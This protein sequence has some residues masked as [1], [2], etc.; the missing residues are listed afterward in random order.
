MAFGKG[1]VTIADS[2][3]KDSSVLKH[4]ALIAK[5]KYGFDFK[6]EHSHTT[7][8]APETV[9]FIRR[10]RDRFAAMGIDYKIHYPSECFDQ[11]CIRKGML[12]TRIARFCCQVLKETYGIG[13]KVATGVRKSE[14]SFRKNNQGIVTIMD[15][16]RTNKQKIEVDGV[17]FTPTE[18]G[19]VVALNYDN[20]NVRRTVEQCYRT[21]KVLINPL[22]NW[23]DGDVWKYIAE[24]HI[25]VN[26]LY[27]CGF[28]RVGC[29]GC[30][31]ANFK[32]REAEFQRYPK[33]RERYIRIATKIIEN[34]K[35]RGKK[36]NSNLDTGLKYFKWWMEDPT[37][38]GQFEFDL[39]GNIT[40]HY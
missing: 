10:E 39:E 6:V 25:E 30:P 8:D 16:Q 17:N 12:P 28:N 22:I 1:G 20:A 5:E 18:R 33:Y 7:I 24:H 37:L 31:M 35:A 26:P 13:E 15:A 32:G 34:H 11:L 29:V 27:E 19:G 9:Y 36:L 3:G 23:T 14:S 21:N 40:E 38:E 2:G 4:I